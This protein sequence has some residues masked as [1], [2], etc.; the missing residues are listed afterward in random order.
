MIHNALAFKLAHNAQNLA[1]RKRKRKI[2]RLTK[3]QPPAEQVALPVQ[4]LTARQL[5]GQAAEEQAA[6]H[7]S[8]AGLCLLA[9]NLRCKA[10]E[11]DLVA[12]DGLRLVFIEVRLRLSSHYGGA[13]ASVNRRKQQRLILAAQY[14]LPRLSQHY[15]HGQTPACRFDVISIEPSGLFWIKQAFDVS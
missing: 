11:I 10:G 2:K 15:F 5:A 13:S 3:I 4:R 9:R 7:I 12:A 14:F 1:I 6:R 8:D